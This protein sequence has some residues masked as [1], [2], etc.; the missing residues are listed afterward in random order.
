MVVLCGLLVAWH[1]CPERLVLDRLSRALVDLVRRRLTHQV[2]LC[3]FFV[4]HQCF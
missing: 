1:H 3:R 2:L 4:S